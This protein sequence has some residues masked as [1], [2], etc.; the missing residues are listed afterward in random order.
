MFSVS[1]SKNHTPLSFKAQ[2]NPVRYVVV[3]GIVTNDKS[4]IE[5]VTKQFASR[6]RKGNILEQPLCDSLK[7]SIPEYYSYG[8]TQPATI[9]KSYQMGQ[10]FNI[11]IGQA[12]AGLKR[13][14]QQAGVAL[15]TKK[16]QASNAVKK[17]FSTMPHQHIAI[18]AT[19]KNIKG[20]VKYIIQNVH[21]TL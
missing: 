2:V 11:I 17:I 16:Q 15:E 8:G 13:I 5:E 21:K 14:W 10:E 19:T 1:A 4:V 20:K 18:I 7:A 9:L 12:A 3:D 6:L